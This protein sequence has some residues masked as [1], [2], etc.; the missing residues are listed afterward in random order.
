MTYDIPNGYI[1]VTQAYSTSG[2][3]VDEVIIVRDTR[4]GRAIQRFYAQ[5]AKFLVWSAKYDA[6]SLGLTDGDRFPPGAMTYWAAQ[7][8][9][10][11]NRYL[12]RASRGCK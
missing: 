4:L 6:D 1:A 11:A 10:F 2:G 9:R 7:P 8:L 12:K 3:Y 5:L